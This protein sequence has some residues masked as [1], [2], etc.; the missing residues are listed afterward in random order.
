MTCSVKRILC[1]FLAAFLAV[2]LI[3]PLTA[4]AEYT[5]G[6]KLEYDGKYVY[7]TIVPKDTGDTI[8]FTANGK[9]PT[10]KSKVYTGRV[11]SSKKVTVKAV[12]FDKN[13]NRTASLSITIKPRVMQPVISLASSGGDRYVKITSATSGA[14]IYYT[15][16]G[17]E[18][19]KK[20]A[21]YK[22]PL[23]YTDGATVKAR[24]YKSGMTSSKTVS[25]SVT[26]EE[27]TASAEAAEVFKAV[28]SE[29]AKAGVSDLIL[30]PK[31]CEAAQTRAEEIAKLYD[32]KRP[33]GEYCKKTDN[34]NSGGLRLDELEIPQ[35]DHAQRRFRQDR[36]GT[37]LFRRRSLLGT[38]FHQKLT[39]VCYNEQY[40]KKSCFCYTC[41]FYRI[42]CVRADPARERIGSLSDQIRCGVFRH[43]RTA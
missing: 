11:K 19:T 33:R 23:P 15:T 42:V 4:S 24:A 22:E 41:A 32:H 37:L 31:L 25:F 1:V 17:S 3:L 26:I 34:G 28:N 43:K 38:A 30:D 9:T 6:S 16:D 13:G 39:E 27:F 21:L 18:P 29:R 35:R 7:L 12:E 40:R 5:L 20:S 10:K 2:S 8:Y 14:K 36:R